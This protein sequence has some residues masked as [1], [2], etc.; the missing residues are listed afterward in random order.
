[1]NNKGFT[2]IEL[3]ATLVILGLVTS[4]GLYA[5]RF[6]MDRAKE[7]TEEVFV[8]TLRDAVDVYL[9]SEFGSLKNGNECSQTL[10]K[11]HNTSVSVY[12]VTKNGNDIKFSDI[13]NSKYKPLVES[14]FVNPANKDVDGK[15]QCNKDAIIKVYKD[16]DYVYYYSIDKSELGCLNNLSGDYSSVI[17]NLPEGFSCE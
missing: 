12:R 1:M 16:E 4:L 2:L 14:E 8:D 10:S 11:K 3:V 15:Y 6:N 5:L 9:S 7:K 17:T 13:I